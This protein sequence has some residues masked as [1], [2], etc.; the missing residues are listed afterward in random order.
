MTQYRRHQLKQDIA[1]VRN[2]AAALFKPLEPFYTFDYK[3][4]RDGWHKERSPEL[5]YFSFH[6]SRTIW[7]VSEQG[8][9]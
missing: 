3:L 9:A 5:L 7:E 8:F 1:A 2:R 4:F 6:N